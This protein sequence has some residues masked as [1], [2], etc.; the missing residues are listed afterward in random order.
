MTQ[1]RLAELTGIRESSIGSLVRGTRKVI[2]F[3]DIR[4]IMDA[5]RINNIRKILE[6]EGQKSDVGHE[7]EPFAPFPQV[8]NESLVHREGNLYGVC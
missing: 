1:K 8:E 2:N 6:V 3:D 7:R 5:L 4:K